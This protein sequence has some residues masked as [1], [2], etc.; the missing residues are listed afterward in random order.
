MSASA[1][2]QAHNDSQD[3]KPREPT[4]PMI[5][6]D[7]VRSSTCGTRPAPPAAKSHSSSMHEATNEPRCCQWATTWKRECRHGHPGQQHNADRDQPD[8][9]AESRGMT[10]TGEDVQEPRREHEHGDTVEQQAHSDVHRFFALLDCLANRRSA[11]RNVQ[12]CP[13]EMNPVLD[14]VASARAGIIRPAVTRDERR[15][16]WC[17]CAPLAEKWP[18]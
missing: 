1:R 6:A 13:S 8:C 5:A 7:P 14:G 12:K 15:R 9:D 16:S 17:C 18:C 2:T 3:S 11:A 4:A 10:G